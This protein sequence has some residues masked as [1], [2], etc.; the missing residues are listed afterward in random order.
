MRLTLTVRIVYD[1]QHIH[2]EVQRIYIL[3]HP[4]EIGLLALTTVVS[5]AILVHQ[6]G[7]LEESGFR[8]IKFALR[9]API[10]VPEILDGFVLPQVLLHLLHL[11]S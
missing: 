7:I 1:K 3:E 5:L 9:H 11:L 2:A 10:I 6:R 4:T 8:V